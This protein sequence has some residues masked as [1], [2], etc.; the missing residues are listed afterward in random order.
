MTAAAYQILIEGELDDW[1]ATQFDD[2]NLDR[3]EGRTRLSTS[4]IDQA[5]LHGLFDRLQ[6]IG[7][8]IVSLEQ[9]EIP[10]LG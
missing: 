9:V 2:L 8:V 4:V 1:S 5:G 10:Q 7:A 6:S 3:Q